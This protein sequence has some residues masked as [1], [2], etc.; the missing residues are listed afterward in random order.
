MDPHFLDTLAARWRPMALALAAALVLGPTPVLR[1]LAAYFAGATRALAGGRPAA[2]VGWLEAALRLDPHLVQLHPV[3]AAAALSADDPHDALDHLEMADRLLPGDPAR[4]CLRGMA[5]QDAGDPAAALGAWEAEPEACLQRADILLRAA[6]SALSLD[7]AER[8]RGFLQSLAALLP[9]DAGVQLD[10]GTA[11]AAA[12]PAAGL[13]ILRQARRLAQRRDP[14]ADDLIQTILE[15]QVQ[16]PPA[17]VLARVGQ[18]LA[19]HGRWQPAAWA[20]Q[21]AVEL[22]PGYVEAQ[23]YL[24]LA[25]DRSGGNGQSWLQ[26]AVVAAPNAALPRTFLGYHWQERGRLDLALEAFL[27]AA[28]L[29]P[30]NPAIAAEL[31]GLYEAQGDL[32]SAKAAYRT[33]ASLAPQDASFW[34][35]LAE[36]SLRNEIEVEALG[37]PAAR[38]AAALA[39]DQ[40]A[41]LEALGYAYYLVGDFR[42]A[43]RFLVRALEIDPLRPETQLRFGLVRQAQG[44]LPGARAALLL[45]TRL[46]PHGPVGE[47]AARLLRA[48][49][50]GT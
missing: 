10:L 8:Y 17:F 47:T 46:D 31:G 21:R 35:L 20:L 13:P 28:R 1:P 34:T 22:E 5:L 37:L 24:G 50:R 38:N 18:T 40:A 23:A 33:A 12:D 14:L 3:I 29:E 26:A 25:L 42:M 39:S 45:A 2:A 36:F 4:T 44:D 27:L 19:R 15:A 9:A 32:V 43:E 48:F 11:V 6:R 16:G 49:D 30:G 7:D 41:A